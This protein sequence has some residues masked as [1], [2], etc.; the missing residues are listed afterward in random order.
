[1][2]EFDEKPLKSVMLKR[3]TQYSFTFNDVEID[4]KI[5]RKVFNRNNIHLINTRKINVLNQL[6]LS[7]TK[8]FNK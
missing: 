8:H 6:C 2:S 5:K 3:W 1:M 4:E 7:Q